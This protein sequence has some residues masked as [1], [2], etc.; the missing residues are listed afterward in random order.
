MIKYSVDFEVPN[1]GMFKSDKSNITMIACISEMGCGADCCGKAFLVILNIFIL[2]SI[3]SIH[4]VFHFCTTIGYNV[5]LPHTNCSLSNMRRPVF[6][7]RLLFDI[8]S[9][10][11]MKKTYH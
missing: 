3:R 8:R 11:Q 4:A 6:S 10:R 2:V 9:N 7:L 1:L 5:T